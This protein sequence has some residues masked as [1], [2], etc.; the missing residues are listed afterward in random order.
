MSYA[1]NPYIQPD[2]PLPPIKIASASGV[3]LRDT[4]GKAYFDGS[5][6]AI[7]VNVGHG[8]PRVV[9]AMTEAARVLTFVHPGQGCWSGP[10]DLARLLAGGSVWPVGNAMFTNTGTGAVEL[11][12][13]SAREY[14]RARGIRGKSKVLTAGTSYHGCSAYLLAL[15]GHRRRRPALEDAMGIAPSFNAPYPSLHDP[16]NPDHVCTA[17]CALDVARVIDTEG[18]DT[19]AAL[20]IEPILGSTGGAMIPPVGYLA[21][22][23]EICQE[24]DVLLIYDEVLVGLGRAGRRFAFRHFPGAE[25]DI[26]VVSKG[27]GAGYVPISAVL[28]CEKVAEV[29]RSGRFRHP[30]AGTLAC[31]N[32]ALAVGIAVLDI[33]H[34]IGAMEDLVSDESAFA[35]R[36]RA[37]GS[38]LRAGL[39]SAPGIL[40]I[41]GRGFYYGIELAPSTQIGTLSRCREAGIVLYPFNGYAPDGGGEGFLVAPPLTASNEELSDLV[42]RLKSVFSHM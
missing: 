1:T 11:A 37:F 9:A 6:G 15:S 2:F 20:L 21:K 25:P 3:W 28:S 42:D 35:T 12:I 23:A 10:N 32:T 8:H 16:S 18:P 30:V 19:V 31:S 14:H 5:S 36:G 4:A 26:C 17:A 13:A 22:L 7:C 24:R 27:L 34:E 38:Q 39:A 33:L 41:R 29:M 40:E